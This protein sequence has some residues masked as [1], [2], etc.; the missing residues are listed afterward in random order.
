MVAVRDFSRLVSSASALAS[1]PAMVPIVSLDRFGLLAQ[2]IEAHGSGL[3]P[4]GPNAMSGGP[5]GDFRHQAFQLGQWE[6]RPVKP[7]VPKK[8]YFP[9][10]LKWLGIPMG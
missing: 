7:P 10:N 9:R 8:C 3:R 5:L 4:F 6:I 2:D 1:A